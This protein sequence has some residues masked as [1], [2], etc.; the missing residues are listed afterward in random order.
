MNVLSEVRHEAELDALN[1]VEMSTELRRP[2]RMPQSTFLVWRLLDGGMSQ[3]HLTGTTLADIEASL[4][5]E[6]YH[7]VTFMVRET[8]TLSDRVAILHT[9]RVRRCK[10]A[11]RYA[12]GR[13]VYPYAADRLFSAAV[14]A[15]DPVEPWHWMPGCDALGRSNVIEAR[16]G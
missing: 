7:G 15:F 9:Y 11:G 6:P 1:A 5:V 8:P 2:V 4:A 13:K 10:W 14:A 3:P 16:H 12:D